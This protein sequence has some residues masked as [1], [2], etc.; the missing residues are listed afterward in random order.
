MYEVLSAQVG[1]HTQH[2]EPVHA[3]VDLS[4]TGSGVNGIAGVQ[5]NLVSLGGRWKR[6]QIELVGK[7]PSALPP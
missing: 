7:D 6:L 2:T 1:L 4:A 3:I 5:V